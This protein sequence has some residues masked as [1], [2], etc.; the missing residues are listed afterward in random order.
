MRLLLL[1]LVLCCATALAQDPGQMAAMQAAQQANQA[2]M[3]ASQQANAAAMQ[4]SQQASQDAQNAAMQAAAGSGGALAAARPKFSLKPGTYQAPQRVR[5]TDSTRGA[6]IYYT[7]DGWTPTPLSKQYDG[8]IQ[9]DRTTR[10]QAIAFVPGVGGSLVADATYALPA[11]AP[12]ATT[13]VIGGSDGILHRGTPITLIFAADVDSQTA[14]VG[15][16]IPLRLEQDARV[17]NLMLSADSTVAQAT[18]MHVDH[19]GAG[20]APGVLSFRVDYMKANGVTVPLLANKTE[21]G[22]DKV[23]KILPFFFIPVVGPAALAVH[24]QNAVIH[25]GTPVVA[26]VAEDTQIIPRS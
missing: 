7:T 8:P 24:G 12:P 10:L 3:Q 1:P 2:A 17:G 13:N 25:S 18:V 22:Q 5:L 19:S 9:I 23:K 6:T 16:K 11:A 20:G 14:Q 26:R 21:E 15:D 4:A